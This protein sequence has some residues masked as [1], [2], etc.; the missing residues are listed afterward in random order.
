MNKNGSKSLGD[1]T[2]ANILNEEQKD[3]SPKSQIKKDLKVL[4]TND[5]LKD[6]NREILF[7]D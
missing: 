3:L 6:L 7:K 1:S 2:I 4:L 5:I